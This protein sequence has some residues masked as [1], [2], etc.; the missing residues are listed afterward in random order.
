MICR[1]CGADIPEGK[2]YCEKCG[3]AIQMVPDYNPNE[4]FTLGADERKKQKTSA[5]SPAAA[6]SR[7]YRRR[8]AL[9]G[10]CLL[11]VGIL[12]YQ[13][14]YWHILRPEETAAVPEEPE[15]LAKPELGIRPGVYS[16]SPLLTISHEEG[17]AGFIYYTTDGTTP[18]EQSTL[19]SSPIFV[20]EGTTVVRAVFVRYD[21]AQSEEITGTYQVEFQYPEEPV[22][23]VPAGSYDSSFSV[24]ITAEED[25]KIYYTTNGEE[26]GYQSR[27]YQGPVHIPAGLTVLQAV[28]VDEEGGM[29][30]IV[31]AVY[32]VSE[33][34]EVPA[35]EPVPEPD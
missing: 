2:I 4:D 34:Y 12:A 11:A 20:G 6:V 7:W 5:G 1:K 14:S 29:S 16:Y 17:D 19:Y 31:E 9:A 10:V 25:C 28:S 35:E 18:D 30:G 24:V 22:F 21:G 32:A 8:Y 33:P 23:S 27:L 3:N 15:L 26:P 13:Y